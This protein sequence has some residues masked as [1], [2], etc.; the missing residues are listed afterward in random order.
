[1]RYINRDKD[2]NVT[3]IFMREQHPGQ[4]QV[5][6]DDN[7]VIDF[8]KSLEPNSDEVK[9]TKEILALDRVMAIQSLQDKG[10]LPVDYQE[11]QILE[12]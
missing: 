3:G 6:V 4:E 8:L 11:R 10:E 2:G 5:S 12:A 7:G 9:I 1:M